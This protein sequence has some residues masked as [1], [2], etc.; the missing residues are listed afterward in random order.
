[1]SLLPFPPLPLLSLRFASLGPP[2][3]ASRLVPDAPFLLA[4]AA[5]GPLPLLARP[6]PLAPSLPEQLAEETPRPPPPPPRP[7]WVVLTP[8]A[9]GP[10]AEGA[11]R[12]GAEGVGERG[13]AGRGA[14]GPR[15]AQKRPPRGGQDSTA[16]LGRRGLWGT[17]WTAAP[18]TL[19]SRQ[20]GGVRGLRSCRG[21]GGISWCGEAPP[22]EQPELRKAE[23]RRK[24]NPGERG[25]REPSFSGFPKVLVEACHMAASK[26]LFLAE[27]PVPGW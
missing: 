20:F 6:A 8:P 3:A 2:P 7:V 25:S 22:P 9:P 13:V 18:E 21:L 12:P 15:R 10:E 17:D 4:L 5:L 19:C 1:M 27:C 11:P 14:G 23:I 16:P 24:G 26:Y